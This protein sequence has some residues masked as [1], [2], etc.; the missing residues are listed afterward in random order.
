M[1]VSMHRPMVKLDRPTNVAA[2]L[3]QS[4]HVVDRMT[5]NPWFS[6]TVP[7]L[8]EVQARID[9]LDEAEVDALSL[10]K[11]LKQIRNAALRR[12]VSHMDLLKAFVQFTADENAD[13]AVSIIES[14]GLSVKGRSYPI[15]EEF[16]AR[17]G[18]VSGT[19]RLMVVSAGKLAGYNWEMSD[20][21][22]RTWTTLAPT[23]VARTS[24][25]ALV[26]LKTYWFRY[27]V[28]VR[29]GP[30]DWSQPIS[31]VVR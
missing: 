21:G 28:I 11:G 5:A 31:F 12:L 26:P 4:Q 13:Q 19:V 10:T 25:P 2:F 6:T 3:I 30:R 24:V 18:R 16:S 23:I 27:R 17:P 22:G 7:T 20:D 1:T 14:A 15:K 8:A 29:S 9:E